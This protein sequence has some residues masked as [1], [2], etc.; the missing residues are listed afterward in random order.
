MAQRAGLRS[1]L[2]VKRAS[3]SYAFNFLLSLPRE[4]EIA[5]MQVRPRPAHLKHL[6]FHVCEIPEQSCEHAA[7][8][9][10]RAAQRIEAVREE[11]VA[12]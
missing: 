11:A 5:Q 2:K 3:Q 6:A 1:A 7:I 10:V 9:G 4:L 12:Q 8:V